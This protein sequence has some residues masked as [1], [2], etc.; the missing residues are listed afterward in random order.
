MKINL[1]IRKA[2]EFDV[3][4]LNKLNIRTITIINLNNYNIKINTY[5]IQL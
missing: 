3:D 1:K 5:I 2:D 4:S